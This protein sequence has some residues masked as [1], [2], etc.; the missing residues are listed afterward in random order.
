MINIRANNGDIIEVVSVE[1]I[2]NCT[3][4]VEQLPDD[5]YEYFSLGKYFC[6][7]YGLYIADGWRD[8][9]EDDWAAYHECIANGG[10]W[11]RNAVPKSISKLQGLLYLYNIGR[12]AELEAIIKAI[13][14]IHELAYNASHQWDRDSTMI[15]YMASQMQMTDA[16]IDDLFI[17]AAQIKA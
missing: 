15:K 17:N 9:T 10:E 3:A 16:E 11:V 5:F 1:P 6:N 2:T 8:Y 14:G 13:D 12:L 7:S 4:T